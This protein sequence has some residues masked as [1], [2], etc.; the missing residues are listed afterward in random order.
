MARDAKPARLVGA[1][2]RPSTRTDNTSRCRHRR[3]RPQFRDHPQHV[4]EMVSPNDVRSIWKATL[5]D[6]GSRAQL[7]R[8]RNDALALAQ[9]RR[10]QFVAAVALLEGLSSRK[11]QS[12]LKLQSHSAKTS[13]KENRRFRGSLFLDPQRP[14]RAAAESSGQNVSQA[15][16]H[17]TPLGLLRENPHRWFVDAVGEVALAADDVLQMIGQRLAL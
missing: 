15:R 4:N 5:A 8:E 1:A 17:A 6:F 2:A 14:R 16:P 3:C 12:R 11:P 7:R 10:E 9:V 13:N